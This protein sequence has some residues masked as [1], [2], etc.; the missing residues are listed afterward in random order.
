MCLCD[1]VCLLHA[2][3]G[4]EPICV[5]LFLCSCANMLVKGS[6]Y[7]CVVCVCVY[8]VSKRMYCVWC[9][10]VFRLSCKDVL[11][12]P[13]Q[14]SPQHKSRPVVCVCNELQYTGGGLDNPHDKLFRA[15]ERE[16]THTHTHTHT[17]SLPYSIVNIDLWVQMTP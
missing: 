13:H 5:C 9:S 3:F 10:N 2:Q 17:Q 15:T 8:R 14:P 16:L 4:E 11:E 6:L 12:F 7:A 1:C